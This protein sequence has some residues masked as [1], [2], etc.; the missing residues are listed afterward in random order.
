MFAFHLISFIRSVPRFP[1]NTKLSP[2][3]QSSNSY[4]NENRFDHDPSFNVGLGY[5]SCLSQYGIGFWLG[6]LRRQWHR[7][8]STIIRCWTSK[9]PWLFHLWSKLF[10]LSRRLRNA[11]VSQMMMMM[12]PMKIRCLTTVV[13]SFSPSFLSFIVRVLSFVGWPTSQ[14]NVFTFATSLPK[15]I[16]FRPK[17]SYAIPQL[18]S[19]I[20]CRRSAG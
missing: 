1:S 16:S 6:Y 5:V 9:I 4:I 12:I 20:L 17:S 7:F 15:E 3:L 13:C 19:S 18:V 2:T 11:R 14:S 8:Q 10:S